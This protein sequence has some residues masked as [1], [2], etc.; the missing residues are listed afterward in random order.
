MVMTRASNVRNVLAFK[1]LRYVGTVVD[2]TLAS[3][4]TVTKICC[5]KFTEEYTSSY[6]QYIVFQA[7]DTSMLCQYSH[8]AD[9]SRF[10]WT[11]EIASSRSS[12]ASSGVMLPEG[13]K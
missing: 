6:H 11:N 13:E 12:I 1:R 9:R 4:T 5:W 2:N 8:L 7:S 10:M 3:E